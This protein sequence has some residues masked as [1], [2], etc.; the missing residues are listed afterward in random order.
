MISRAD[1]LDRDRVLAWCG[2]LLTL[3]AVLL[4]VAALWSYGYFPSLGVSSPTD[5]VSFY[6]AGK[7]AALGT[8]GL[9]YVHGAHAAAE[10]AAIGPGHSY[11]YFYYPP[12]FLLWCMPLAL[13]PLRGAFLVFEAASLGTW[14]L[15][16]HHILRV[17]GWSWCVPVLAYPAVI[18]TLFLG[19]NAFVTAALF[20][21]TSL[22]LDKKPGVAG[23]M[24]GL[25]C[26]KPQ[27]ALIAPIALAAGGHWRAFGTA[28]LTVA[29]CVALSAALFGADIW[30]A[31]LTAF[32][33]SGEVYNGQ[34]TLGT[35]ITS[36]GAIRVLGGNAVMGWT[37]QAG[38]S[39]IT[40]ALVA[41]IWR[42]NPDIA[43]RSAALAAGMLLSAPVALMYD[44]TLLMVGMAWLVRLGRNSRF[45]PW[46]K[47]A[48]FFCFIVPLVSLFLAQTVH[49][50]LG[51]LA[52]AAILAL[53]LRR[54]IRRE[55]T[56]AF[57][58]GAEPGLKLTNE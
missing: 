36:Y 51:P 53:S 4:G 58:S 37:I 9:S 49:I 23:I 40:A 48:L 43:V 10:A 26:Y 1:W 19:Q 41:W 25:I 47:L 20:G 54:T 44:L 7:L 45:L 14:L 55:N 27:L 16:A 33:A 39:I 29:F 5:F 31:Y 3:E 52:P 12:T 34:V 46:E 15:V 8:P 35:Y 18:W 13:L 32:K 6:A 50:P 38:I 56:I 28:A 57:S 24:L 42:R 22:L 11:V 21:A 30:N 17:R 2:V